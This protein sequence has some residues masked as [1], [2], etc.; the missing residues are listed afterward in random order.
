MPTVN[1]VGSV[2]GS[3]LISCSSSYL[4]DAEGPGISRKELNTK[5]VHEIWTMDDHGT[6]K[7][8]FMFGDP[9]PDMALIWLFIDQKRNYRLVI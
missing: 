4:G 8:Y 9:D 6:P 2:V 5:N 7:V 3:S 1:T